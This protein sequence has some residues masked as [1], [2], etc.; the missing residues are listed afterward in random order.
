MTTTEPL[1]GPRGTGRSDA[2]LAADEVLAPAFAR[3]RARHGRSVPEETIRL[4]LAE[5][6]EHLRAEATVTT[7]L[8]VLAERAASTRIAELAR[9]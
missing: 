3:L 2:E 7:Y 5:C 6:H 4:V 8:V 9:G 1:S